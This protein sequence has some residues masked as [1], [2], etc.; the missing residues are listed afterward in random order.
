MADG[1][2]RVRLNGSG[3]ISVNFGDGEFDVDDLV[4][5]ALAAALSQAA[6]RRRAHTVL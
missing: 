4:A 1:R 3:S 5:D 2:F 6:A